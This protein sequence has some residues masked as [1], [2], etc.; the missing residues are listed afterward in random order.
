M[1]KL[2]SRHMPGWL[3]DL[4]TA[5]WYAALIFLVFYLAFEPKAEFNYL[6]L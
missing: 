2:L 5:A 1:H 6:N 4:V 3:A